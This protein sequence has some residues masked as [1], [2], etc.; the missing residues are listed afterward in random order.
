MYEKLI[1]NILKNYNLHKQFI[2]GYVELIKI[3]LQN[4]LTAQQ[5]FNYIFIKNKI[6]QNINIIL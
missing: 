2:Q 4:T 3:F 6:F 5:L 1:K